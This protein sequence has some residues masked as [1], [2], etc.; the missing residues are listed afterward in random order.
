M[1]GPHAF[2]SDFSCFQVLTLQ[3][4]LNYS[5]YENQKSAQATQ[6]PILKTLQ[7]LSAA[8]RCRK[9]MVFCYKSLLL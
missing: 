9:E 8:Q 7:L 5:F 6:N 3:K 2:A 1:I 4:L